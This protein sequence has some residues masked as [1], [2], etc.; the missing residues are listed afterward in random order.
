VKK[1]C[2]S[3]AAAV[4]IGENEKKIIGFFPALIF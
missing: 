1:K 2:D 4:A 3:A